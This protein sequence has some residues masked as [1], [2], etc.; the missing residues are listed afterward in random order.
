MLFF[1]QIGN[2][3]QLRRPAVYR[4]EIVPGS[5]KILGTTINNAHHDGRAVLLY[6]YYLKTGEIPEVEIPT[7]DI[8][9]IQRGFEYLVNGEHHKAVAKQQRFK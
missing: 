9:A 5:Y 3:I 4:G 1:K 2:Q 6:Q 7:K 8:L